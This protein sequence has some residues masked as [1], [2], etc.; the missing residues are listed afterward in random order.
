MTALSTPQ[1][2]HTQLSTYAT[3]QTP[4]PHPA[5]A[6]ILHQLTALTSALHTLDKA[7]QTTGDVNDALALILQML[8]AAYDRKLEA[9]SLRCLIEP[10]AEKLSKAV[11]E[12][13][14]AL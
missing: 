9:D 5:I 3:T 14:W 13:R 10:L 7:I 11:D 12:M 2:I 8:D 6:P 4:I 1:K